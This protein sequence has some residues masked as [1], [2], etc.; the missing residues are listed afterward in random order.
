MTTG[1]F[2]LDLNLELGEDVEEF[3]TE[4]RRW[5]DGRVPRLVP[6][7]DE[8]ELFDARRRWQRDLFDEGWAGI[9]WPREYGGRGAGPLQQ[10]V[11]YEELTKA[12]APEPVNQPGIILFGP[13]LMVLGSEMLKKQYLPRMLSAEDIWCQGFS[14]PEAGSDLA[15]VRT[16]A[17]LQDDHYVVRGQKVWTSWATYSDR[18]ALLCRTDPSAERHRG[19]SMLILDLHQPTVEAR[20]ITQITGDHREFGELFI[21]GAQ[22]PVDH[23]AGEPGGGWAFAMAMLEHERSDLGLHNHARLQARVSQ[24]GEVIAAAIADGRLAGADA[25]DLK[26]R[27][28]DVW[29]RCGLLRDFNAGTAL[30]LANGEEPGA[31]SSII[32]LYWSELVQAVGELA[33]A[34][35]GPDSAVSEEFAFDFLHSRHTTIA[36]GS[37]QIQR[38]IVA[39]RVLGLPRHRTA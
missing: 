31:R 9:A 13:T 2:E 38:D 10:F 29:I 28:A 20:P 24:I 21:D 8:A 25:A 39:Q 12:G 15:G 32:R 33:L 14:E 1:V 34:C 19:L 23:V 36:S 30:R 5:L 22:V 37:Q 6:G 3:R 18:C 26:R 35:A 17:V 11:Y 4:L 7:M 16:T 27:L